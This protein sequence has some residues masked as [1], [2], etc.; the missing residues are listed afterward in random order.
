MLLPVFALANPSPQ[1]TPKPPTL[2]VRLASLD[3]L[4]REITFLG[5]TAGWPDLH[6]KLDEAIK[7]KLGPKGLFG[8][9]HQRPIGLYGDFSG[10]NNDLQGVV[11]LPITDEKQFQQMLENLGWE[12]R[13]DS[14]GLRTVK[15]DVFPKDV[16]YRVANNYAYLGLADQ[17]TLAADHL[18][19]PPAVFTDKDKTAISVTFRLDQVPEN[20]RAKI[21]HRLKESFAASDNKTSEKSLQDTL[22]AALAKD[23][24]K[25]LDLVLAQGHEL[26]CHADIDRKTKQLKA[27]LTLKPKSQTKL[28]EAIAKMGQRQTLFSGILDKNAALNGLINIDV[29]PELHKALRNIVQEA[30]QKNL[31]D[32]NDPAQKQRMTEFLEA[33][34]PSLTADDIDAAV[35]IRGP[36]AEKHF[37][38]VAGVKLRQGNKLAATLQKLAKELPENDRALIQIDAEKAGNVAIHRVDL[39]AVSDS[40][41]REM[42]GNNP[43]FV[44]FRED[45]LFLAVGPDSLN[46]LKHAITSP[47]APSA[48][49][50]FDVSLAKVAPLLM[51]KDQAAK[52]ASTPRQPGEDGR[53]QL[54]V[55]GGDSLRVNFT[56]DLDGLRIFSEKTGK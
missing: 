13:S 15:Q 27:D 34:K 12:V 2:V 40:H 31:V 8:I 30:M 28:A 23:I 22:R 50:Q 41:A 54:C 11:M 37:T 43:L 24:A 33:L 38:L 4:D 19:A 44:A 45:A 49:V 21:H 9:D 25:T 53:L 17:K 48:P 46:V 52:A 16:Q 5:N 7:S 3:K 29:P 10:E 1:T 55:Q 18:L 36:N 56:L 32:S 14:N 47:A 35:S 51:P 39:Q 20:L 26:D 6:K 42:F